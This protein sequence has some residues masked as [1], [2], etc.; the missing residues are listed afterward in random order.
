[1]SKY[2]WKA[3]VGATEIS[4]QSVSI[5][6]GRQARS[7]PFRASTCTIT[8]VNPSS[9]PTVNVGSSITVSTDPTGLIVDLW[10]WTGKVKDY[11]VNYGIVAN[12]DTWTIEAECYLAV[13]G[14]TVWTGTTTAGQRTLLAMNTIGGLV[15]VDVEIAIGPS[16]V[17]GTQFCSA[18]T[19]NATNVLDTFNQIANTEQGWLNGTND[20]VGM[21]NRTDYNNSEVKAEFTDTTPQASA[22]AAKF[23]SLDV[24]G[25]ADQTASQVVIQPDG[26]AAQTAGSPPRSLTFSTFDQTTA[27]AATTATFIYSSLDYSTAK[28][29][30]LSCLAEAQS[31]H[32]ALRASEYPVIPKALNVN[33]RGVKTTCVI[34]GA[35]VSATPSSTRFTYYL[36]KIPVNKFYF[37]LD[38]AEYGVL[39]VNKL[40]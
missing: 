8:G 1:M 23:D 33:F 26:L 35:T 12:E 28:P 16:A 21:G 27:Q 18:I 30:V 36:T 7:D 14:R 5:S 19:G 13:A 10:Q 20:I 24:G 3:Y 22:I 15:N 4:F 2:L 32:G 40:G 38:S 34:E 31:T 17:N 25:L 29:L 6:W 9:L 11:S 39:D 37:T